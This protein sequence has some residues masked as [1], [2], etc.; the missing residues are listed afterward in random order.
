MLTESFLASTLTPEK[1][2]WDY[3][4]GDALHTF[5]LP[6]SPLCLALDPA[7]RAVYAGYEDGSVQLLDFYDQSS[8]V[9]SLHDATL[10]Y[11]PIQPPPSSRWHSPGQAESAII[12]AQLSY[13]GTS[14]LT[15]HHN[16]KIHSWDVAKGSYAKQIADFA[17]PI[18]NLHMLRPTG[19]PN[20]TKLNLKLQ[21][22]VKPRYE[23]FA[24][25]YGNGDAVVPP[26]YTFAAQ[27]TSNLPIP[28][29]ADMLSF[30]EALNH[31][32][33]PA[34]LLDESLAD[35]L[36]SQDPTSKIS[37]SSDLADLRAQ[38]A[39]LSSQLSSAQESRR[40]AV[41]EVEEQKKE[42][43]RRQKDEEFKATSKKRRRLERMK[44][45][46]LTRKKE[47]G[48]GMENANANMDLDGPGE[49]LS[50]STDELTDTTLMTLAS[51]VVVLGAAVGVAGV[52]LKSLSSKYKGFMPTPV[53]AALG[54]AESCY[55]DDDDII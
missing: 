42:A 41:A 54:G 38:N 31:P 2:M 12:C 53:K 13:D 49:D 51:D 39:A 3:A 26:N 36:A 35:F 37:D 34:D 16:G 25:G 20:T 55:E 18:T 7:D 33:F 46:E 21:N 6:L 11:T 9:Q 24:N 5:L 43:W 52:G 45:A 29:S 48:E 27:Y 40:I 50:S 32:C 10:R 47:M 1:S 14:L 23:S 17:A 8:V 4:N 19:F 15:G 30:Q 28:G 44:V 22:V